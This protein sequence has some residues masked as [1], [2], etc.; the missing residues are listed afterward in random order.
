MANGT[1]IADSQPGALY[2][3]GRGEPMNIEKMIAWAN[4]KGEKRKVSVECSTYDE[5]E[6]GE[7][8]V[9]AYDY[10]LMEGA[11]VKNMDEFD[12]LDEVLKQKKIAGLQAK[13]EELEMLLKEVE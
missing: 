1:R 9:W 11:F 12:T 7:P 6:S 4:A 3:V 13:A 8:K 10:K 5:S 2:P